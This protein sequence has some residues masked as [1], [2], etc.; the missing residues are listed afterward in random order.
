MPLLRRLTS[1]LGPSQAAREL[2]WIKKHALQARLSVEDL[3]DRRMRDEPLQYILG[4]QPFGPLDI[5]V[6]APVLIPRPETEHWTI[7]LSEAV[8]PTPAKP[9]RLLDIGTGTGCIPLLLCH[10]WPKGSVSA[11]GVDVSDDA[12]TLSRENA[13]A[14]GFERG[15]VDLELRNTFQAVRA[16]ILDPAFTT[17]VDPPYDV[18]TSNPPYI[19]FHEYL[20]LPRSVSRFEDPKALFGG[21]MDGLDF[22]P[23][24]VK[25][26]TQDGFMNRN[27][28][29]ALEIGHQQGEDVHKILK[30]TGKFKE[31]SIWNDPWGK[32]RTVFA[33]M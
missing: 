9:F 6:R 26:L 12:L 1:L 18:V 4:T 23:A 19:P 29:V 5:R 21:P 32:Q 27:G 22:Y 8:S 10:L 15:P 7:K 17:S 13:K 25:V 31:I 30:Q 11:C 28:I 3:V 14:H 24:I 2:Q 16:N 20:D 33:K